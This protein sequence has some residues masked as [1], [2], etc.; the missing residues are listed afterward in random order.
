MVVMVAYSHSK[1]LWDVG[2][3]NSHMYTSVSNT[4]ICNT[5]KTILT[6][7]QWHHDSQPSDKGSWKELP[8]QGH[9]GVSLTSVPEQGVQL[10]H[11]SL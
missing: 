9:E 1:T 7:C 4:I 10:K 2:I 8:F 6:V 3:S 11:G 5:P